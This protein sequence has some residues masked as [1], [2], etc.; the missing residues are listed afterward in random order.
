MAELTDE[1]KIIIGVCVGV[2]GLILLAIIIFICCV[3]YRKDDKYNR[4]RYP[5]ERLVDRDY[6]YDRERERRP[7]TVYEKTVPPPFEPEY[8]P[9][10][11]PPPPLPMPP[12]RREVYY[13]R[14]RSMEVL[15][16][17]EAWDQP[18][19]K[20]YYSENRWDGMYRSDPIVI[21]L[22]EPE[23]VG[24]GEV[25]RDADTIYL[26][27]VDDQALLPRTNY[28]R[29]SEYA[30]DYTYS[31]PLRR[32]RSVHEIRRTV[33]PSDLRRST[34]YVGEWNRRPED[35][36]RF[37]EYAMRAGRDPFLWQ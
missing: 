21:P 13:K 34:P 10:P 28:L 25:R 26:K 27:Y 31:A 2:A 1:Q 9:P 14:P 24:T 4:R 22:A 19:P 33:Q 12:L 16:Y 20:R 35:M 3:F 32:T 11:P 5:K 17:D 18:Q 29:R 15:Q 36:D 23:Y 37:N 7:Y 30:G 6:Y 8:L